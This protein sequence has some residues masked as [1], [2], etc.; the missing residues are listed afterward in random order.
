M[1]LHKIRQWPKPQEKN[2]VSG[3][4]SHA[5]FYLLDFL[6]LKMGPRGCPETRQGITTLHCVISHKS[7]NFT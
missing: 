4:V 6:T 7:A 5:A 1:L 3:N 2:N